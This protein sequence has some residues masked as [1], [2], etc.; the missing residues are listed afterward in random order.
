MS[1]EDYDDKCLLSLINETVRQELSRAANEEIEKLVH[2]FRCEIGKHKTEIIGGLINQIETVVMKDPTNNSV[3]IQI[4][5]RG[6]D[7]GSD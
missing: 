7:N 2:K 6:A 4:N 1:Y 3:N 5:I